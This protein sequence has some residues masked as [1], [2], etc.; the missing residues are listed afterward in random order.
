MKSTY[1]LGKVKLNNKIIWKKDKNF[2]NNLWIQNSHIMLQERCLIWGKN[3][4]IRWKIRLKKDLT[5]REI[6]RQV[7]QIFSLDQNIDFF[8][9]ILKSHLKDWCRFWRT[10]SSRSTSSTVSTNL[11]VPVRGW[12][13]IKRTAGIILEAESMKVLR[14]PGVRHPF[15]ILFQQLSCYCIVIP[16]WNIKIYLI[17]K[18]F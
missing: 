5:E 3:G 17:F 4:E 13:R 14:G 9:H 15:Y 10:T 2:L 8:L 16:K 1:I 7:R 6:H 11:T 18:F 12:W